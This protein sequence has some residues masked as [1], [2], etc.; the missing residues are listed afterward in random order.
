MSEE[1]ESMFNNG[2]WELVPKPTGVK[3]IGSKWGFRIKEHNSPTEPPRFMAGLCAKG[4]SQREGIDYNEIFAPVVKYKTLRLLLDMPTV[5]DWHLQQ[6]DVK[7]AFLHGNRN[8][9]IYMSQAIGY[10]DHRMPDHVC[11][12]RKSIYGLKQSP[13]HWNIKF[14]EC[15]I[16][17]GFARS[18]YDT[19][20]YLKRPKSGLILYLL[21]YVDD[22]L[23]MSNSE[24]E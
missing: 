19:C 1:I 4:F 12:L 5:Y 16:S 3:V 17:L 15:M 7:T 22:I 18:K 24:S 2:T 13:R 11:L 9:T 10:V 21:M 14:N 6:M 20:L 23:I 8:E